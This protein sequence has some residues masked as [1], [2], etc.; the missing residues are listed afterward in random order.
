M[1]DAL[2]EKK[3]VAQQAAPKEDQQSVQ[4]IDN[5][6]KKVYSEVLDERKINLEFIAN[7]AVARMFSFEG[8]HDII[9]QKPYSFPG[10]QEWKDKL[11]GKEDEEI[12]TLIEEELDK[13]S[14]QIQQEITEQAPVSLAENL[15]GRTVPVT[16]YD[17]SSFKLQP[18][19]I[20]GEKQK[21]D[22]EKTP[23]IVTLPDGSRYTKEFV[24][25][26]D[27]QIS[28]VLCSL[29]ITAPYLHLS[30]I[31][32]LPVLTEYVIEYAKSFCITVCFEHQGYHFRKDRERPFRKKIRK[33]R[34]VKTLKQKYGILDEKDNLSKQLTSEEEKAFSKEYCATRRLLVG[35][36]D[37][38]AQNEY[39]DEFRFGYRI[40][41]TVTVQN[42]EAAQLSDAL[43]A[44][45]K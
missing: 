2:F 5:T 12:E 32:Y 33:D 17:I 43:S 36:V 3:P 24:D 1:D 19:K 25:S 42:S 41:D 11:Q 18:A 27:K 39:A 40:Y 10:G 9:M 31:P 13:A 35:L 26:W 44:E 34:I 23:D 29:P 37:F 38:I 8:Y 16:K 15:L 28:R 14:E 7:Q 4:E 20:A 6:D 21:G 30:E 22:L 45:D